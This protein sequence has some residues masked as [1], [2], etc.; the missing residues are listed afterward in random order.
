MSQ[1]ERFD[2]LILGSREARKYLAFPRLRRRLLA[3]APLLRARIPPPISRIFAYSRRAMTSALG[4]GAWAASRR[5]A[6]LRSTVGRKGRRL[7]KGSSSSQPLITLFPIYA[8][9]NHIWLNSI[10]N[11][12]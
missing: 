8:S 3:A 6:S 10:V 1:P 12:F 4:G 9:D 5:P 2:V 7:P 11:L